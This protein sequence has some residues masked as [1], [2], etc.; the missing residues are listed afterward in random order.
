MLC[1][2]R[3]ESSFKKSLFLDMS[4]ENQKLKVPHL[5]AT[6]ESFLL[7]VSRFGKNQA[8][9]MFMIF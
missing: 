1:L 2:E 7:S 6:L 3:E 8:T 5:K 9:T 4:F